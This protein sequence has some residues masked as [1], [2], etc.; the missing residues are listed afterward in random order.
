ML[1]PPSSPSTP[2]TARPSHPSQPERRGELL[3]AIKA[4]V[5]A[6]QRSSTLANYDTLKAAKQRLYDLAAGR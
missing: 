6:D 3:D 4:W 1:P 5:A 2:E